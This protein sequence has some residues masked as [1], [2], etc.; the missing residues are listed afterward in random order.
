MKIIIT[1]GC[2]SDFA[3]TEPIIKRIKENNFFNLKNVQLK[4]SNF[5]KSYQI[6]EQEI[7]NFKPDLILISGDR[8]EQMGA[9]CAAFIN[10]ICIAHSFAGV[11]N[12]PIST[13]DDIFRHNISLMSN[14]QFV[15]SRICYLNI[16]LL[17]QTINKK[18]NCYIVGNIYSDDLE[19]DDSLVPGEE[20]DLFLLNPTT[21]TNSEIKWNYKNRKRII[22]GSNPDP[23]S[24]E[25][26][27][28]LNDKYYDNLPRPQFLG[29]LKNCTRFITNSSAA[30]YE[31][32][33]FLKEDQIVMVSS[34]NKER[35]SNFSGFTFGASN[36][37]IEI[38][39]NWWENEVE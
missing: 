15:E 26:K 13:L 25:W 34:R 22:I 7:F 20:Y 39:K 29:L 18:T 8:I 32:P 38:L 16:E 14:I 30:Y 24:I 27:I 35:S 9:T 4:P 33:Y 37:I 17:F 10:N 23:N 6:T 28:I 1:Q 21:L 11:L 5:I 12:N 36:R 19:I 3:I 31:A 2:R